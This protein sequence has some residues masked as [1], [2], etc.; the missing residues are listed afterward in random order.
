V[1]QLGL[2]NPIGVDRD[3][4]AIART[5]AAPGSYLAL[6]SG[7]P[8]LVNCKIVNGTVRFFDF[9]V[10]GFRHALVDATVLRYPYPTGGPVWRLPPEIAEAIQAAYRE[11]LA[12][13]CPEALD[14]ASYKRGL[15]AACVAW[16]IV[17]MARV[18]KVEAGPDR[19]PW[20]LVPPDWTG[21]LPVRSRRRQL[22][23]IIE[24]CIAS[25]R[26]AGTLEAFATWCER[27][28]SALRSR[29]PEATEDIPLYPAFT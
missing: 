6:S 28:A 17:R 5:L 13:G 16:T 15:A 9:E 23:A 1:A 4:D 18:A 12:R 8:G 25:T 7:D 2:P 3:L 20:P 19:E 22:V 21:P 29:W 26:H 10:A 27:I 14:D 24:T 11:E